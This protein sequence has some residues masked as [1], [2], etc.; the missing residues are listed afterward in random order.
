MAQVFIT[1]ESLNFNYLPAERFGDVKFLTRNDLPVIDSSPSKKV[2]VNQIRRTLESF[3]DDDYLL[4]SGSPIIT[5]IAMA[6]LHE[7]FDEI[8][9]LKWSN[10]TRDYTPMTVRFDYHNS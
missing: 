4:P 6:I 10:N 3:Q 9:V 1:H 5:G 8:R 2:I 7:R